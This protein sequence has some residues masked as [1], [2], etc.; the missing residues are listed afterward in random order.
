MT[1][2]FRPRNA[3]KILAFLAV[4]SIAVV[5]VF[6]LW[7][8]RQ[9]ELNGALTE[10]KSLTRL[11]T[12]DTAEALHGADLV[13]RGTQEALQSPFGAKT[14]LDSAAIHEILS[15]RIS[16][17]QQIAALFVVDKDGQ[18]VNSS[19]ERFAKGVSVADRPYFRALALKGHQGLFISKPTL[20]RTS[21]AWRIHMARKLTGPGGQFRGVIVVGLN[22]EYFEHVYD[23]MTLN[24]DRQ[25]AIYFDDGTLV[26][27][28]PPRPHLIGGQ[29][30]EL[31]SMPRFPTT[32]EPV[33]VSQ[34]PDRGSRYPI[35]TLARV[36]GY[37]VIVGVGN[38]DEEVLAAWRASAFPI[39]LGS[40]LIS[41]VVI[42]AAI[43]LTAK[44]KR[45][46]ALSRALHEADSRFRYM[47]D[48]MMDAIITIDEAQ[49]VI[50]FNPAA[51]RMFGWKA[52]QIMGTSI[53][54]LVPEEARE[55]HRRHIEQFMHSSDRTRQMMPATQIVGLRADGKHFPIESTVSQTTVGGRLQITTTMRDITERRRAETELQELNAQLRQLSATLQN[56]REDERRRI[57]RE[58]HD[59]LGQQLTGLKLDLSWLSD[60]LKKGRPPEQQDVDLMRGQLD[61]AIASVR[62]ISSELRPMILDDL[63]FAEAVTWLA[64]ETTKRTGLLVS[65]DLADVLPPMEG[66]IATALFRIVQEA[67]TNIARHA[68]ASRAEIRLTAGEGTLVLHVSDNGA[69][70]EPTALDGSGI[71]LVSM[72]ERALALN[73][74]FAID[75][76]PGKGTRITVTVPCCV[77]ANQEEEA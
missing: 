67:L 58:L 12:E 6:V 39:A 23:F 32:G 25:V 52:E 10:T 14:P 21:K 65:L 15:D 5:T 16:G 72:R 41:L 47:V 31:A 61:T 75:A 36:Q 62:R 9:R 63:G 43:L 44:L 40:S 64:G 50:V 33:A 27:S 20:G 53:D 69:G 3:V 74:V 17:V 59:E 13:L 46:E 57:S 26:A 56:I 8:L 2:H 49:N 7:D 68:H 11:L 28:R 22:L 71:G 51:E 29:A 60:R 45:E 70:F 55:A 19:R 24:A 37:P 48:S 18:I 54:R 42:L 1:F 77:S 35:I 66:E 4:T 76:L 34:N 73:G 30:P 38:D